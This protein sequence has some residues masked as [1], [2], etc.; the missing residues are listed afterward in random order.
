MF[1]LPS[2][3]LVDMRS[4]P[5]YYSNIVAPLAT[6]K[7]Y[8]ATLPQEW[9]RYVILRTHTSITSSMPLSDGAPSTGASL[10][11]LSAVEEG[12]KHDTF[13]PTF[14]KL[15][16]IDLVAPTPTRSAV[17]YRLTAVLG[18]SDKKVPTLRPKE[19]LNTTV[20]DLTRSVDETLESI[21]L[22]VIDQYKASRRKLHAEQD[23]A[24]ES[25]EPGSNETGP[26]GINPI[27]L[28]ALRLLVSECLLASRTFAICGMY[29][30]GTGECIS[31]GSATSFGLRGLL[32][33]GMPVED[34]DTPVGL[35]QGGGCDPNGALDTLF[36]RTIE[37]LLVGTLLSE[38]GETTPNGDDDEDG[39]PLFDLPEVCSKYC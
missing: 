10:S 37:A 8:G 31:V 22:T 18:V 16:G 5:Q 17:M 6:T 30:L 4:L 19:E 28:E 15:L 38:A 25:V 1:T 33:G 27:Q 13:T 7:E 39:S 14:R 11:F 20:K 34:D 36:K 21:Y 35:A 29:D 24:L 26:S 2:R 23:A 32:D 9:I 3:V 12:S